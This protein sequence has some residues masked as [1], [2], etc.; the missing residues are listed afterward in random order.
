MELPIVTVLLAIGGILFFIFCAAFIVSRFYRQVDQGRALIINPF[1]GDPVVTFTGAVV[2]PIINRA[3]V[4][5]ISLKTVD[6]D[7]RGKEGLICKD[8]IRADIKVTFFVRVNKTRE[9]VLKV[10]QSIG[11]ARASHQETLENLF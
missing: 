4:M 10:A 8:N 1:K 6:I 11:C 3:E 9:D 2:W 7:R 5:D